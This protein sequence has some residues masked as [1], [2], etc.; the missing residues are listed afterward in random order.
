MTT[1]PTRGPNADDILRE[2]MIGYLMQRGRMTRD[3]ATQ[4]FRAMPP[5]QRILLELEMKSHATQ[6][7]GHQSDYDPYAR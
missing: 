1:I 7:R 5:S 3:E 4:S 6:T 2:D